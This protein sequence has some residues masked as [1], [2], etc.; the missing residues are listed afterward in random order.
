MELNDNVSFRPAIGEFSHREDRDQRDYIGV[1]CVTT[2]PNSQL[3]LT[4][5]FTR[6]DDDR[7]Q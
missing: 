1:L 7:K 6:D 5:L 3:E 2:T 4:V